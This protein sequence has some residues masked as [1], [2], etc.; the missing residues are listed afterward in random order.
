VVDVVGAGVGRAVGADVVGDLLGLAVGVDVIGD[1]L[2]VAVVVGAGVWDVVG[3]SHSS[4]LHADPHLFDSTPTCLQELYSDFVPPS[5][6]CN[7]VIL[8]PHVYVPA[9]SVTGV[10]HTALVQVEHLQ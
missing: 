10:F 7:Q 9:P 4:G 5:A 1:L 2:G 3:V 6:D 8:W